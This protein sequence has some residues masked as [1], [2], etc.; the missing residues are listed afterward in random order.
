LS[1]SAEASKLLASLLEMTSC[2]EQ[3][4]CHF[5]LSTSKFVNSVTLLNAQ[6]FA[7]SSGNELTQRSK[8]SIEDSCLIM[9]SACSD[10][11]F[12]WLPLAVTAC[13]FD[14]TSG[15]SMPSSFIS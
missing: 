9:L 2:V 4:D 12:A 5:L 3:Q 6:S 10:L 15:L 1:A 11:L 13:E 14:N 7:T 8:T